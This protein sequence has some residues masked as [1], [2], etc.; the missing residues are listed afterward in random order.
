MSSNKNGDILDQSW[1]VQGVDASERAKIT[2][3]GK[4]KFQLEIPTIVKH[5]ENPT[6]ITAEH[7]ILTGSNDIINAVRLPATRMAKYAAIAIINCNLQVEK[8]SDLK[9]T[10]E[11]LYPF[12]LDYSTSK[13][14]K[15]NMS[16]LENE[17]RTHAKDIVSKVINGKART[18]E[19]KD[20]QKLYDTIK[21]NYN[22][23]NSPKHKPE[24]YLENILF[25]QIH[26]KSMEKF[27]VADL[28]PKL[29]NQAKKEGL[30]TLTPR[31]NDRTTYFFAGA[32]AS[33]KGTSVS[34]RRREAIE[35]GKN[36]SDMVK[37]NTDTHR[38]FIIDDRLTT[39]NIE[40]KADY[41]HEEASLIS[42]MSYR[43]YEKKLDQG[44]AAD[45]LIDAVAVKQ[46]KLDMALKNGGQAK[47][48]V[49]SIPAEKCVER[50]YARGLEEKRFVPTNF[51]ISANAS[52]PREFHN[53][54]SNNNGNNI[55]YRVFDNDVARGDMPILIEEGNLKTGN[56]EVHRPDL[57]NKFL[58]KSSLNTKA[59]KP[60]ELYTKDY[61]KGN[62]TNNIHTDLKT[63]KT[64]KVQYKNNAIKFDE[65]MQG[66]E[67]KRVKN[68]FQDIEGN[69]KVT[70][71]AN[72]INAVPR[73]NQSPKL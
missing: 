9:P 38:D 26:M 71:N 48:D 63:N 16:N 11:K 8:E 56:I 28:E 40:Q 73:K 41:N 36:W 55:E 69:A 70:K 12:V 6:K 23:L 29:V 1:Q 13:N 18:K 61:S 25:D 3:Q 21:N 17:S 68:F 59:T 22:K 51:I 72:S 14:F 52:I 62:I 35:N 49:V 20:A 2:K 45:M 32:P 53:L 64:L 31:S 15:D 44:L 19:E 37:I 24:Q 54:M 4:S 65:L 66:S 34:L 46:N 30:Q 57:L 10:F 60:D 42:E 47:I 33:G 39:Q 58:N 67:F 27:I 43:L 50:A 7:V 5:S